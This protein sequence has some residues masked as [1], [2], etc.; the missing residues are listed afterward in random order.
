MRLNQPCI[1]GLQPAKPTFDA[2]QNPFYFIA[3]TTHELVITLLPHRQR[4]IAMDLALDTATKAS[5]PKELPVLGNTL[6]LL[7]NG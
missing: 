4:P 2:P 3:T 6:C 5:L 1:P 7:T